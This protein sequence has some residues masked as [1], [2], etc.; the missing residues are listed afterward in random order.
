VRSTRSASLRRA[1][2]ALPGRAAG[3]CARWVDTRD[4]LAVP[5]DM[6]GPRLSQRHVNTLR[7]WSRRPRMSSTSS[8]ST[9]AA[10]A[11][12][13][14]QERRRAHHHG[15]LPERRQRERQGAA[16]A[17][18]VL[19][20]LASIKDVLREWVGCTARTSALRRPQLLP[21]QRHPPGGL[22]SGADAPAHGRARPR[23]GRGLGHHDPHHGLHQP[24]PAAR[25]AGA[26]AGA[27]C[28]ASCCRACSRSSTRSTPASW[29]GRL[30]WPGDMDR[31]AA[32]VADR[33]GRRPQVR[34]AYLAIVGSFS[35]NGVAALH[36]ELLK[37]GLFRDFSRALAG[38]VQQQ[39]QRRHAAPLAGMCNPGLRELLDETI[40]EGWVCDLPRCEAGD[41]ADDAAFRERWR[42]SSATTRRAW[43][44]WSRTAAGRVRPLDCCSTCRSSASTSTSASC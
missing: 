36:S 37:Q 43:R 19:P 44:S 39:D 23:V 33:G 41:H 30:R 26:L 17:P 8:S 3:A 27:R 10:T 38:E 22:G 11:I 24:H 6:P 29:R 31:A 32:H 34:M 13:R 21:A 35:V 28:S 15:A 7:L 2:R 20:R 4:V 25:G 18:A 42:R 16:A 14:G 1:H 12:G 5:Y 40:G 9:P